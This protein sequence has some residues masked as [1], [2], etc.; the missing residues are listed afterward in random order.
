[1]EEDI[2]ILKELKEE[3]SKGLERLKDKDLSWCMQQVYELRKKQVQAIEN[4]LADLEKKDKII[5]ELED[6]FNNYQLCEYELTDCTYRKCEYIA[7]N[8]EPPCRECIKQYFKKKVEED[9]EE[10]QI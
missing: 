5:D 8:E 6:I 4:I 1:M 2:K 7:D 10:N 3:Y 9:N